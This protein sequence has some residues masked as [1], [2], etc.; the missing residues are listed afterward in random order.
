MGQWSAAG[1]LMGAL[2]MGQAQA[3][4]LDTAFGNVEVEGTPERV[5]TL[6][7]GAL[8]ASMAAGIVP[9][10]AVSTRG[11]TDVADY[12]TAYFDD[13]RPAM[14]G[15]VREI[16]IEAVLAQQPDLILTGPQLPE[17]QYQLLS[18][19]APTVVPPGQDLAADNWEAEARL[20]GEALDCE[21]AIEEAIDA[22][23]TRIATLAEQIE[24]AHP[25]QS[26]FVVRWMPGGP[27]VMSK[28][29]IATGLL[30]RVGLEVSDA[31]LIKEG[32]AHSDAL[33]LENLSMID[34]D[35]LFLATLNEDG[36]AALDAARQSAAFTR[37]NV[38]QNDHVVPVNGQLWS[39]A[40]GPL[41]AQAILD[42]IENALLP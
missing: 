35:W 19:I 29:L 33:S 30:E 7:E 10:G 18:R 4:T 41:A 13:E 6:Y 16:N 23:E 17:E 40:S 2:M 8:D 26:A 11:G 25:G 28:E 42:D 21:E 38:V 3:R 9:L 27:M 5:V 34:G 39:S 36:E 22:V 32:S 31:G 20:F 14:V 15:V 37:L 1:A 24:Q 12:I